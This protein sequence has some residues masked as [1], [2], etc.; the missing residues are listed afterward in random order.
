M[1]LLGLKIFQYL[2]KLFGLPNLIVYDFH[3]YELGITPSYS[4]LTLI[5]RFGYYRAQRKYKDPA[6]VFEEF[7]KYI[8]AKGYK[9]KYMFDVYRQ[10]TPNLHV[11]RWNGD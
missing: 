4:E 8:L 2:F 6:V 10:L 9:S 1:Q 5:P 3:T 7:V 11:W